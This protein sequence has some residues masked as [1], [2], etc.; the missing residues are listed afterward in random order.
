MYPSSTFPLVSVRMDCPSASPLWQ[1]GIMTSIYAQRNIYWSNIA[2]EANVDPC[3]TKIESWLKLSQKYVPLTVIKGAGQ[4][5]I[6]IPEGESAIVADFHSIR[7]NTKDSPSYLTSGFYRIQPGPT[8]NIPTYDYEETKYVLNGQIDVLDEA[9]G[10]T[11]H[12]VAGDFAFF[13]VGSKAQF[14]SKSGGTAF[15]AV[16][17]PII[18]QH[19]GLKGREEVVKSKL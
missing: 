17:R 3:G 15:F 1:P 9:T 18:T 7:T 4:E 19:P 16:T 5:F 13:H 11:H 14:S 10:V 12:L 8:R 6:P 2:P